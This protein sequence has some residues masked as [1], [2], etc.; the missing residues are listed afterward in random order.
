MPPL[1]TPKKKDGEP[2]RE[3]GKHPSAGKPG[4]QVKFSE[5]QENHEQ[6]IGAG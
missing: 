5:E 3:S 6:K 1:R 2:S 4:K